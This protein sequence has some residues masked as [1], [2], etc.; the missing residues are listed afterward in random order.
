[1]YNLTADAHKFRSQNTNL[2]LNSVNGHTRI[3]PRLL[4]FP[5]HDYRM[6][7]KSQKGSVANDA[8]NNLNFLLAKMEDDEE[9]V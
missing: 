1:M 8:S 4:K 9:F 6:Q 2:T 7:G 3:P 5:I